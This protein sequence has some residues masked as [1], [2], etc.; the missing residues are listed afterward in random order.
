[1]KYKFMGNENDPLTKK[2]G[3]KKGNVYTIYFS[4]MLPYPIITINTGK[5][6]HLCP[7][8]S[9]KVFNDNWQETNN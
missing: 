1:M 5:K 6:M 9:K 8:A 4:Q 3:I 7:Y 2:W